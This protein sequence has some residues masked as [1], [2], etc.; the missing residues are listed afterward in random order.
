MH[1]YMQ[2]YRYAYKYTHIYTYIQSLLGSVLSFVCHWLFLT[3]K[4]SDSSCVIISNIGIISCVPLPILVYFLIFLVS[5]R[6]YVLMFTIKIFLYLSSST[7]LPSSTSLPL[8][9]HHSKSWRVTAI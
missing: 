1:I 9:F 5:P 7:F 2:I 3:V 8:L 6:L 4:L